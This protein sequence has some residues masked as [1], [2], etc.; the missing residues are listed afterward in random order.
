VVFLFT[1]N[2][3]TSSEKGSQEDLPQKNQIV[4]T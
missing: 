1:A 2:E 3:I 4:A